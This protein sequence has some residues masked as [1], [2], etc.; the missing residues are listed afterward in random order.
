MATVYKR[1]SAKGRTGSKWIVRWYD[2]EL[3][4]WCN[5]VAYTDK[6]ASLE[7]GE[8]LERKSARRAEGL[9]DP[10]DEHM[11]R[12]IGDHLADYIAKVR[13]GN[14]DARYV[15]QLES[16]VRRIIKGTGVKRLQDLDPVK[17]GRLVAGLRIKGRSLSGMTRNEYVGSIRAFTRWAVEARRIAVD[18]LASLKR[19]ERR[20]VTRTHPRR[21]LSMDE[22][23]RLLDATQRR[24][25]LELLTVRTGPRKGEQTANV[26]PDWQARAV[27][28]GHERRHC[29]LIAV[30]TGLRRSEIGALR[31]R[32][33]DLD[34]ALPRIRLRAETTKSRRADTLAIH[35]ELAEA[36]REAR[37]ERA[38]PDTLVVS[39]VPSM[40][41]LQADLKLAG[42]EY[43]NR[44]IGYAD[45]HA[46]RST[47]ST[48]MAAAGMSQRV[49]QAHMRHSDPRLTENTYMDE[50]LLPV[51]E[52]LSQL[53][54]IPSPDEPDPGG[55]PYFTGG[56]NV[57]RHGSRDGGPVSGI[58]IEMNYSGVR[59]TEQD[60]QAFAAVLAEAI[61]EFLRIHY[62]YDW[63]VGGG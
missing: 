14:R 24:P 6:R 43:G 1:G 47:L 41:V 50:S 34:G 32:D 25:L 18:P 46:L 60:R 63:T 55:N 19:A 37:P 59:Q 52:E 61:G 27:R 58:Q 36:L 42:I 57:D 4:K 12:K 39:T 51:A 49:R 8:R 28:L 13:A 53:P 30:W 20:A 31:W 16:R 17:V 33:I 38:E 29:Y 35:P 22:V 54:A 9:T 11:R 40:R 21:A 15:S 3:G 62:G 5:K 23:G 2:A 45:F 56:Y 7:M 44:T 26:R 10:M 48:M